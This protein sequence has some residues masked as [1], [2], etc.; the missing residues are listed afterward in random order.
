MARNAK[1]GLE[2]TVSNGMDKLIREVKAKIVKTEHLK[3]ILSINSTGLIKHYNH[4]IV[5]SQKQR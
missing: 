4:Q 5:D 1:M 3:I 2:I